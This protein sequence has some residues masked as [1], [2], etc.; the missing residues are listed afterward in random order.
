MRYGAID[1]L[2][3]RDSL[4]Q[5]LNVNDIITYPVRSGSSMWIRVAIIDEIRLEKQ[6]NQWYPVLEYYLI[7]ATN[8]NMRKITISCWHR[9][10]KVNGIIDS[11][12]EDMMRLV[13]LRT[14]RTSRGNSPM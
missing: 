1:R 4:G 12:D 11:N 3:V 6:N 9:V 8:H 2:D 7:K 13:N 5:K 14:R 10:T